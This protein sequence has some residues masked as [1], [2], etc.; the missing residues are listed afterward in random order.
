MSNNHK[1]LS[2]YLNLDNSKSHNTKTDFFN[3]EHF[4][5]TSFSL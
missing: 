5:L 1:M 4:E 2:T 3:H